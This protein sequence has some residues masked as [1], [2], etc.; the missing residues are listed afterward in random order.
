MTSTSPSTPDQSVSIRLTQVTYLHTGDRGVDGIDLNVTAGS[1]QALLG[2]NG[3]GKST[4]LSIVGGF[5]DPQHGDVSVLGATVTPELR[6]RIG[7]LFQESALD[8]LMSVRETLW[9]HGRLFGLGGRD[10]KLRITELLELIGIADRAGESVETLS[11]G[12]KRRLELARAVLHRPE[13]VLLDEPTLGLDPNSKARLW[14]MLLDINAAGA[15]ILVATNDVAEAERYA[16]QVAFL[17]R[18]QIIAQGT[19]NDLKRDL[20]RDSVRVDWPQAPTDLEHTL[21]DWDGVGRVT[22]T[23]TVVHATVDNASLFVPDLFKIANGAIQG[24]RIHESTLEDAYFQLVGGSLNGGGP[25][26]AEAAESAAIDERA[27]S[28]PSE[29]RP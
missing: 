7:I 17:E 4:I 15:T 29:P 16:T 23:P 22:T 28:V 3:S 9:L 25:A 20:R 10:L 11:G 5:R 12:M 24:I 19:P 1:I 21:A 26:F 6:R 14:E 13:L 27:P 2:P 8:E 18:G